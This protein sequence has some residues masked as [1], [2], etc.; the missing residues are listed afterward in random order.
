MAPHITVE[1]ATKFIPVTVSVKP[2][3]PAAADE[4]L[5][6][7]MVG[8][9]TTNAM[10]GEEA[11]LQFWTVTPCDPAEASCALVTLAVSEVAPR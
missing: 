5:S 2:A 7:A 8:P 1:P 9:P 4:G 10:A 3:P 11:A 6:D